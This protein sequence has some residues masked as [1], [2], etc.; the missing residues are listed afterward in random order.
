MFIGE[1]LAVQMGGGAAEVDPQNPCRKLAMNGAIP[2]EISVL[3]R[4]GL[5]SSD[6]AQQEILF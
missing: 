3:G 4:R 2:V 1:V 5:I 6:G